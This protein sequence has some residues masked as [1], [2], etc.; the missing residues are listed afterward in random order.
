[1]LI[2]L[3]NSNNLFMIRAPFDQATL[4]LNLGNIFI[5]QSLTKN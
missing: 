3:I 5:E 1:M 2:L 4:F